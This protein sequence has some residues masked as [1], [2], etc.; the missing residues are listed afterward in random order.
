M[1]SWKDYLKRIYYDPS[2]PASFEGEKVLY[3][4]VKKENKFNIS[5]AR[6]KKWLQN[7]DAYTVNRLAKRNFQRGRV[8]VA[9]IDD[10][11]D[12]DLA[13]LMPDA[14][15]NDGF[16]YLLAVVDIFSRFAWVEPLKDK[17]ATEI[18]RGFRNVLSNGRKPNRLRTDAATDFTSAVFQN[19]IK[20]KEISHFTTHSEKQANYVERFIKTIKSKIFRHMNASNSTRY[21]DILPQLVESY[22]NTWHSGIRSEPSKVNKQN[23]NKLWW[24]MYWPKDMYKDIERLQKKPLRKPFKQRKTYKFAVGDKVRMSTRRGAFQ[25]EYDTRWTGEI[26]K[27]HRRFMRQEIPM[28]KIVDWF[29]EPVKGSI[30]QAELQKVD[31]TEKDPIKIE[32]L[33]KYKGGGV[34]K[35][36]LVKW[37]NWPK[38][39]NS[40]ILVSQ[41]EDYTGSK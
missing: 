20:S 25:R 4:V 3:N 15:I 13:S 18:V 2:H 17:T 16:K 8:V 24:Q 5:H 10:Q 28:Y 31:Y 7:Q 35:E 19:F 34:R 32:K 39:F 14:D 11:W 9:G 12:A 27:I 6:L 30:Y 33:L 37:Q 1:A 38:K 22:N 40:W 41:I 23:E 36:V 26:F 29:N 21:V